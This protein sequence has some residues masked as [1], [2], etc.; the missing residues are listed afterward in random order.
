M[1]RQ[2]YDQ[3][4]AR[5]NFE[6]Q[7]SNTSDFI[8]KVTLGIQG[9]TAFAA[10]GTLTLT[11]SDSSA[12]RYVRVIR[13][14]SSDHHLNFAEL[15]VFGDSVA[16]APTGIAAWLGSYGLPTNGIGNGS[17]SAILAGDGITNLMK[18]ALG[19]IPL[20]T[21]YSG[22]IVT[23]TTK[24][25]G[26]DYLSLI[27]VCPEPA[28]SGVT[29]VPESCADLGSWSGAGMSEISSSLSGGLRTITVRDMTALGAAQRRFLR[30]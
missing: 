8:S 10:R 15:R 20:V 29:Y 12:Y 26:S 16:I 5:R 17:P 28:P 9:S 19:L 3:D 7:A 11:V 4:A 23:G 2:N 22:R 14:G 13:N 1:A 24:V 25:S 21:G 30:L 27:Y 18:Y 6:V